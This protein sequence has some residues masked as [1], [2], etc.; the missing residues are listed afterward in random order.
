MCREKVSVSGGSIFTVGYSTHRWETFLGLLKQH[1]VTAIADV[2]SQ[3]F[4]RLP[5][6]NRD[7]LAA[8]LKH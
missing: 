4:S 5:E 6:Y 8:A 1:G 2:R 3:P 7:A